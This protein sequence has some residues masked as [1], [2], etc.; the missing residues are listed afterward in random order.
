LAKRLT[1]L[2]CR[3]RRCAGGK[4]RESWAAEHTA[5]GHRRDDVAKLRPE[6]F[7]DA[8][9]AK[10]KTV[11]YARVSSHSSKT[12]SCCGSVKAELDLSQRVFRCGFVADRDCN[13]AKNL[14]RLAASSAVSACGEAR[15]G[16]VRKNRAKRA[17]KMQ[18][19]NG[20]SQ[21]CAA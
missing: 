4:L 18:E 7:S 19:P 1:C 16:A 17:S 2:A 11:A 10:R 12:C 21:L 6:L 13:A 3:L 8:D 5:G 14:E 15:S 20:G 9:A